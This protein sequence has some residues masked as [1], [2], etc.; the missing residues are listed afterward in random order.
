MAGEAK[1]RA[2]KVRPAIVL[3]VRAKRLDV[4]YEKLVLA[5]RDQFDLIV[6]TNIFVYYNGFEQELAELNLAA[7][8][9]PEGIVLSNDA[10]PTRQPEAALREIGFST[11][12]YSDREKDG[13]RIVWMQQRILPR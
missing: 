12:V 4:V 6:G 9:Q 3:R 7:M 13:D 1:T 5:K 8:L 11:T 2:V 10:L